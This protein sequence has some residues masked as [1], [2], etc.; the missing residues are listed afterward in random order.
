MNLSVFVHLWPQ[1]EIKI[2]AQLDGNPR[3][4]RPTSTWD[5]PD[6]VIVGDWF[7]LAVPQAL[8]VGDY[9]VLIACCD[10]GIRF[11]D[12]AAA[13]H[14]RRQRLYRLDDAPRAGCASEL[15]VIQPSP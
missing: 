14:R 15:A 4:T 6:E 13:T 10:R 3:R 11:G 7:E 1:D 2:Y 9:R 8:P 12:W 5:D